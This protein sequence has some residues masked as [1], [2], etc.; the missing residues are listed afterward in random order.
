MTIDP[1]PL[2]DAERKDILKKQKTKDK[3]FALKRRISKMD[4]KADT[5]N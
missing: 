4:K 3:D 1:A 5:L 2:S